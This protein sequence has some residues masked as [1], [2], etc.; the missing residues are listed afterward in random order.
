MVAA[1]ERRI[2]DGKAKGEIPRNAD[3]AT[4]ARY[5]AAV[6]EG[7]SVQARDG[8]NEATLLEIADVALAA[9]PWRRRRQTQKP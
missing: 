8:A 4:L 9:W 3:P 1:L 5:F 2:T 6:I 7:M